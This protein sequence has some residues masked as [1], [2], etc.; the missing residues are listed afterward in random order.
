MEKI[1]R[2][3]DKDSAANISYVLWRD[4]FSYLSER[5]AFLW[6]PFFFFYENSPVKMLPEIFR[7]ANIM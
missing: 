6:K 4:P 7:A 2:E 5:R 3:R 1:R